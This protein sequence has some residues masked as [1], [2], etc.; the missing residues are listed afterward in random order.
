MANFSVMM[1][2]VGLGP[3][4]I[5]RGGQIDC[6]IRSDSSLSTHRRTY[7]TH[8]SVHHDHAQTADR[9]KFTLV[10][11]ATPPVIY[12]CTLSSHITMMLS[13]I[14]LESCSLRTYSVYLATNLASNCV[15]TII[16]DVFGEAQGSSTILLSLLHA[17][18]TIN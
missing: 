17:T 4:H 12:T 11:T 5:R 14:R 15:L 7:D 8:T 16:E 13:S 3:Q 1:I 2:A 10:P 18:Q 6:Q 9:V